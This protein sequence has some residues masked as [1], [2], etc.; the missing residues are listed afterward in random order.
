MSL[1]AVAGA[2]LYPRLTLAQA[3]S[4]AG[5]KNLI[6][7]NCYGG[8]DGLA[9]FPYASGSLASLMKNTCRPTIAPLPN[10]LNVVAGQSGIANPLAYHSGLSSLFNVA[11]NKIAVIQNYGILGDPGRSHDVSQNIIS[12]GKTSM[13]NSDNRGFLAKLMDNQNWESMQYW[14]LYLENPSDVNTINESPMV[15]SDLEYFNISRLGW[16]RNVDKDYANEIS[17][18]LFSQPSSASLVQSYNNTA[19]KAYQGVASVQSSIVSQTVGNNSAGD[20]TDSYFARSMRDTAK[21]LKAKKNVPALGL[22]NK[23]T[24]I[25]L[26]QGG[27]DTHSDQANPNSPEG[28]LNAL[29]TDLSQNLAVFVRDLEANSLFNDTMIVVYS[30]FGRTVFEN[31]SAGDLS[32]GTDHGH[33]NNTFVLGGLV[34]R[35]VYGISPSSSQLTNDYNALNPTIDYRHI[36]SEIFTWMG[37][38]SELIFE[39]NYKYQKIGFI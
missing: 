22:Q 14:A 38:N 10:T 23:D 11:G 7:I 32:V 2:M 13:S 36:F 37:V 9:M 3:N 6:C 31:G 16:E 39:E 17:E 15:V 30:E 26:G 29:L 27:Y 5:G 21:I 4:M 33:G 18:I 12:L 19:I 24:L 8:V 25:L 28:N 1:G 34:K 35:G 20:Y